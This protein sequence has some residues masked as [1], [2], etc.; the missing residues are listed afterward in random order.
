V[1]H[2]GFLF[3]GKE[4][5]MRAKATPRP[6]SGRTKKCRTCR[7]SFPA[8]QILNGACPGCSGLMPLPLRGDGGRFL[9]GL[10]PVKTAGAVRGRRD[11]R[12]V[13]VTLWAVVL[14]LLVLAD[15]DEG[16]PFWPDGILPPRANVADSSIGWPLPVVVALVAAGVLAAAG[17]AVVAWPRRRPRGRGRLLAGGVLEAGS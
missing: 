5:A 4:H 6:D 8:G 14:P 12:A 7:D 15:C 3:C 17:A 16:V 10:T 1:H 11:R 2:D 13:T 9:P